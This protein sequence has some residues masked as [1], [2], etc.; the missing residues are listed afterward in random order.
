MSK[1]TENKPVA[2]SAGAIRSGE[3]LRLMRWIEP[4]V[5]T[6]RMLTAL[7]E[8]VKGGKWFSLIDKVY[9]E[10]TLRRAFVKVAANQGAPGVDHVT[11]KMFEERLDEDLK[12]LSEQLRT[13]T[14]R[15]QAIRR[16]YSGSKGVGRTDAEPDR[17][18]PEA[19]RPG[20]LAGMDA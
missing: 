11:I 17:G 20:R 4:T 16:H 6:E 19:R 8:G 13:G 15:P 1:P 7:I 18:V 10:R 2:V 12:K 14:C 9:A 3:I 5:W